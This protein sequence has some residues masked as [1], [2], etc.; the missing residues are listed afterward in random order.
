MRF[1]KIL[2]AINLK[3]IEKLFIEGREKI[4]IEFLE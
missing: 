3:E 1:L 2:K 4:G